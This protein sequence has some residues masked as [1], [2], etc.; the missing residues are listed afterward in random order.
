M[1]GWRWNRSIGVMRVGVNKVGQLFVP[2]PRRLTTS[3]DR[4]GQPGR[5]VNLVEG[6]LPLW[7]GASAVSIRCGQ[8]HLSAAR[9]VPAQQAA[10]LRP[11]HLQDAAEQ[12]GA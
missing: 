11:G 8:L 1:A 6:I 9:R 10:R 3:P 7:S 5:G 4:G 12:S 2:M